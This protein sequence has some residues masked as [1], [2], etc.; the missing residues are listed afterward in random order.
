MTDVSLYV[1]SFF[2]FF[3]MNS[4]FLLRFVCGRCTC[5]FVLSTFT[6]TTYFFL[7]VLFVT[8]NKLLS[9]LLVPIP[10]FYGSL[11]LFSCIYHCIIHSFAS[12]YDCEYYNK[13]KKRTQSQLDWLSHH[14]HH[15]EH[16]AI[17][18]FSPFSFREILWFEYKKKRKRSI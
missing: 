3:S 14:H 7:Y 5:S 12:F 13:R 18:I 16:A 11:P 1:L 8:F 6:T 17:L 4:L 15:K 9:H 2:L 10:P